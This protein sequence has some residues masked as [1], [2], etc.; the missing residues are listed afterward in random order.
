MNPVL[1]IALG[2]YG[3]TETVG[4]MHNPAVLTYFRETGHKWVTTDETAWCSAFMN[5]C[6]MKAGYESSGALNARSWL[7]VG[8]HIIEPQL[9]D[10]AVFWRESPKSW[11][12]HVGL[13]IGYSMDY[14]HIYVLGGNQN[15]SV[16]IRQYPA[17]QLL[18]FRR[19]APAQNAAA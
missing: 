17:S 1:E 10:V 18:E 8:E 2:Q 5:W 11:K 19:L 15:N 13:F 12:G 7:K 4:A 6:A 3:I 16:C 14:K 9:G